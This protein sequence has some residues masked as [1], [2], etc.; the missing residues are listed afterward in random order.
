MPTN[1]ISK[2]I[3]I[4]DKQAAERLVNAVEESK[5]IKIGWK[6]VYEREGLEEI[7]FLRV[8]LPSAVAETALHYLSECDRLTSEVKKLKNRLQISPYGDDKIDELES[9]MDFRGHE[10]DCTKRKVKELTA[11]IQRKDGVL[12]EARD[13]LGDA[14]TD[15]SVSDGYRY[16]VGKLLMAIDAELGK[17]GGAE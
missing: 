5:G 1:S 14:L 10:L 6:A 12:K 9:A 3:S 15:Y 16:T 8:G 2:N 7:Y 17:V 11:N 4:T 13:L